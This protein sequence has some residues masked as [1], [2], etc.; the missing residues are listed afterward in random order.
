MSS[1]RFDAK[2]DLGLK[3]A[4]LAVLLLIGV[5]IGVASTSDFH[6]IPAVLIALPFLTTPLLLLLVAFLGA[7]RAYAIDPN[8]V[9]IEQW[10]GRVTVPLATIREVRELDPQVQLH[11]V[12][13]VGGFFGYWG[14]YQNQEMGKVRLAATRS[15]GRVLLR[16]EAESFVITP[17]EPERFIDLVQE[18][19]G[20]NQE[21]LSLPP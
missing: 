16:C 4:T 8:S 5:F 6:G 13:G 14:D 21:R 1:V 18:L 15:D 3:A 12:S 19:M 11:R 2:W 9:T 20:R 10:S 17:S 7:P